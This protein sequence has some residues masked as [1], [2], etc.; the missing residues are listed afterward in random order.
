MRRLSDLLLPALGLPLT[1]AGDAALVRPRREREVETESMESG[2]ASSVDPAGFRET[3]VPPSRSRTITRPGA[4][5]SGA[6]RRSWALMATITVLS[7]ISTAPTAGER[8]TPQRYA[9]PAASGIA[10]TL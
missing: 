1:V 4:L 8:T 7:D 5:Q 2:H 10:A 3:A 9:T 6:R